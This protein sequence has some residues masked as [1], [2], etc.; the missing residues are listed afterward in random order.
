[1][2]VGSICLYGQPPLLLFSPHLARSGVTL[3]M[4]HTGTALP[5]VYRP[6]LQ[7][8]RVSGGKM[9]TLPRQRPPMSRSRLL[10][11][12]NRL[13]VIEDHLLVAS[14]PPSPPPP[15]YLSATV[16]CFPAVSL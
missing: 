2:I 1:M 11:Q 8:R 5:F 3:V 13:K 15:P 10:Y 4:A 12:E 9:I 7:T 14:T 6:R 16:L